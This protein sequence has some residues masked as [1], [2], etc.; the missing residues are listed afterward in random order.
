MLICS[1]YKLK[2]TSSSLGLKLELSLEKRFI[3]GLRQENYKMNPEHLMVSE[4]K[5][6]LKKDGACLKGA[7]ANQKELPM[8][9]AATI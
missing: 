1:Q 2:F 8:A 7:E 3:L 4:S 6:V 9:K 5:K